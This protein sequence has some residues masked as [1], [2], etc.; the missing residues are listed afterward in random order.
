[1]IPL[2]YPHI[3]RILVRKSTGFRVRLTD[4]ANLRDG[5]GSDGTA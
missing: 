1:M 5:R 4:S 2:D 3:R